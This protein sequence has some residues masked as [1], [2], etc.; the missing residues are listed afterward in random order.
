MRI[1]LDALPA[2]TEWGGLTT[3]VRQIIK[4]L[5]QIDIGLTQ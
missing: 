2:C 4:H 1:G 3:Y 5:T